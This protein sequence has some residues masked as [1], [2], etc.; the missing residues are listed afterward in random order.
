MKRE[1]INGIERKLLSLA[2]IRKINR[3]TKKVSGKRLFYEGILPDP[4][5]RGVGEF[6]D[7]AS[8]IISDDMAK[9]K[10]QAYRARI[11]ALPNKQNDNFPTTPE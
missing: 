11:R 3:V 4:Y 10:M 1:I 8:T 5:F 9:S 6:G 2:T 7:S